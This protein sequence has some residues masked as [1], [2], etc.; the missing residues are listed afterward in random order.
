MKKFVVILSVA[1]TVVLAGCG[2]KEKGYKITG[3][4]EGYNGP[5]ALLTQQVE[6]NSAE[7]VDG[8]FVLEGVLDSPIAADI[9]FPATN[10]FVNILLSNINIQVTSDSEN[11]YAIK[12]TGSMDTDMYDAA[13]IELQR[14]ID[15]ISDKIEACYRN[16]DYDGPDRLDEE[17]AAGI[18]QRVLDNKNNFAGVALL[19]HFS[20]LLD[21]EEILE[22]AGQFPETNRSSKMYEDIVY[23]SRKNIELTEGNRYIDIELPDASGRMH[24]LSDYVGEGK[25]VLLDYWASWCSPC[26]ANV[27]DLKALYEKYHSRGFEIFAISADHKKDPWVESVR[28]NEMNWIHVSELTEWGNNKSLR[29]YGIRAVPAYFL[30]G[31]DGV[32][33]ES[34]GGFHF[35]HLDELIS[36]FL[37][38]QA[39]RIY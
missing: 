6:I 32:I 19:N 31:P 22:I 14:L 30:I 16:G 12:V 4:I 15:E 9:V 2:Q 1:L 37:D 35:K 11:E 33:V 26:M 36:S 5:V 27:P 29:N 10:Q 23:F 20:G 3:Y 21:A 17:R 8:H 18:K 13:A 24:R 34:F 25:V 38:L 28:K 7:T 39:T